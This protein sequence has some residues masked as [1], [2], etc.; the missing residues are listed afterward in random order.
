[1]LVNIETGLLETAIFLPSPHFNERPS[2]TIIDLL[3]IHGISLPPNEFGG[4][5]VID[6]FC[7]TLDINKHDYFKTINTEVSTHLLIRRNGTVYQ[8]V[9]FHK[10]AWH[11]GVSSF[12]GRANC[13]DYS[14]G[15]ELEGADNIPYE[16]EQYQQLARVTHA[17]MHAYPAI[18]QERITGH[19]NIAPERK[20]DPGPVFLWDYYR[21]LLDV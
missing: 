18:S 13:N 1:M 15:I 3:V 12:D 19:S 6:L 10:R 17:I 14:I 21:K 9:P 7:G 5:D 2:D 11:A 16:E 4:E 8:F 20:T